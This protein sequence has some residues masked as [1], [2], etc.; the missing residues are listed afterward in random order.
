MGLARDEGCVQ[1]RILLLQ[2]FH[3]VQ[4]SLS[5]QNAICSW[6]LGQ[7]EE[8]VVFLKIPS[9]PPLCSLCSMRMGLR[10]TEENYRAYKQVI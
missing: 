8:L 10:L 5:V 1:L 6:R 7:E 3:S 4:A 9:P 2:L